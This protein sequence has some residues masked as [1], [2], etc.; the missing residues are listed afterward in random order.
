MDAIHSESKTL[1]Q[2]VITTFIISLLIS[3]AGLYVGQFVPAAFMLPLAIAEVVLIIVAFWL[4]R[5][6]SIGYLFLY[7][8]SIISGI[9]LFPIVSHYASLAGAQIVLMA[10][11]TT[12]GI[13]IVMGFLGAKIIKKDLGFIGSFLMVATLALVFIGIFNI[14]MSLS[15]TGMLAFSAIGAIV[16]S[17]WILYDFNQMKRAPITEEMVPLLALSLYL[18]FINLFID[19]LRFFGILSSD[20]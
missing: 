17:L 9:T 1:F 2:K 7:V 13:F 18:D 3:S 11:G 10:F 15:S 4:R 8:F 14:F 5:R 20:D 6:K 19:I 16:F 12:S